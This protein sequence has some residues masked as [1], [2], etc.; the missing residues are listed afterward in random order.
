M[1]TASKALPRRVGVEG[2][3]SLPVV[4]ALGIVAALLLVAAPPA[5]AFG[6]LAAACIVGAVIVAPIAGL[7]LLPPFVAFGSLASVSVHGINVGPTDVVVGAL[8]VAWIVRQRR[9]VGVALVHPPKITQRAR[10]ALVGA[11]QRDRAVVA[12]FGALFAYVAVVAVSGLVAM[13]RPDALKE[14]VKWTE[15]LVVVACGAWLLWPPGRLRAVLWVAV[16]TGVLEAV[17]GFA[18]WAAPPSGPGAPADGLR[19]V[20][21]FAQP[22]PYA[23]YLNFALPIALAIVLFTGSARARWLALGCAALLLGGLALADSRGAL[24]G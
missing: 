14:L 4:G 13:S 19:A 10:R 18:Q 9:D 17:V 22:N 11:W 12:M 20:G 2:R 15:V 21:T 1:S 5:G 23:G 7:Y 6:A 3:A 24:L 8:V 16:A